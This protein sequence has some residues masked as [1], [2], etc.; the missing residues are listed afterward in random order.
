[1]V[2]IVELLINL[3]IIILFII[4]VTFLGV[5]SIVAIE[6]LRAISIYLQERKRRR[7]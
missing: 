1:M 6:V 4:Y 7:K 3:G 2:N 5:V